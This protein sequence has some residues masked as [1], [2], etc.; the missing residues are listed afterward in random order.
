MSVETLIREFNK[1]GVT[2]FSEGGKLGYRA[3]KGVLTPDHLKTLSDHKQEIL[4][5]FKVKLVLARVRGQEVLVM[6][7]QA[8][9]CFHCRGSR[10]CDCAGCGQGAIGEWKAIQ[11]GCCKGTGYLS[12]GR[13]Q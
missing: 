11:C 8:E 2:L 1:M 10:S 6:S 7:D 12:W 13:V 9:S 3:P 4:A 5:T